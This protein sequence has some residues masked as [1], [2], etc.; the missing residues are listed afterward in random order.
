VFNKKAA[1]TETT[2]DADTGKPVSSAKAKILAA[3]TEEYRLFL[4]VNA[5]LKNIEQY[6]NAMKYLQRGV[7]SEYASA[8]MT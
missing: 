6:L 4:E 7:L 2:A 1:E 5:H 3:A 8:G